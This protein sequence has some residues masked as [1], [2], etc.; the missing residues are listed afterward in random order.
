[1]LHRLH[2]E[3][4]IARPRDTV[5]G[6]FERPENLSLIT[7]KS[8]GFRILTPQ[9]IDMRQGALIDYTVKVMGLPVH[10]T[11]IISAYDPPHSFVDVQLRGPYTFWHHTHRFEKEGDGTRII[12]DVQYVLPMGPLGDLVNR[13]LVRRQLDTI[14]DYRTEAI[15]RIFDGDITQP[16]R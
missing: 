5:F 3:M 1:M 8:M 10:W 4:T 11:T 12:D 13:F 7:P 15:A 14:F 2:R 16:I 9:P 6:F